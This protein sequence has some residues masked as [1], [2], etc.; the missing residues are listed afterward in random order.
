ML[1]FNKCENDSNNPFMSCCSCGLK[2]RMN[3]Q[4][5]MADF[6]ID[7]NNHVSFFICSI[8]CLIDFHLIQIADT[9]NK[10]I[11]DVIKRAAK[12]HFGGTTLSYKKFLTSINLDE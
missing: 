1:N 2:V 10:Y 7:D 3:A 4:C 9:V 8:N 12:V 5:Y 11:A 6:P